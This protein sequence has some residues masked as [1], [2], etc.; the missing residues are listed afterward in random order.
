MSSSGPDDE[1]ADQTRWR[2]RQ[3][4]VEART[5]GGVDWAIYRT[6]GSGLT[7]TWRM[8]GRRWRQLTGGDVSMFVWRGVAC[9][10]G[11]EGLGRHGDV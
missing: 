11:G 6:G 3:G 8:G 2:R 7:T 10:A 5:K 9:E 4:T 1:A